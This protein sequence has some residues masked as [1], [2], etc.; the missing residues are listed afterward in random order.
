MKDAGS[1]EHTW[2]L[3]KMKEAI[4][5]AKEQVDGGM[6][7][8]GTQKEKQ[9]LHRKIPRLTL[10]ILS[11][12]SPSAVRWIALELRRK[13]QTSVRDLEIVHSL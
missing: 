13:I 10:D 4:F 11:L 9:V 7:E 6:I 1:T 12:K 3:G 2:C 5:P 8:L